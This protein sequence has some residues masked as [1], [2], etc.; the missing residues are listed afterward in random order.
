MTSPVYR[1]DQFGFLSVTGK[2]A[3]SFL[4][5]YTTCDLDALTESSVQLG[6]ICNLQGRMLTSFLVIRQENDLILRMDRALVSSTIEFLRKYIVFSKAALHDISDSYRCFGAAEVSSF[7]HKI[8]RED[9]AFTIHLGNRK[10]IW[11][12]A[13]IEQ[14]EEPGDHWLDLEIEQGMAWVTERNTEKFLPQ[15]FAYH[16]LNGIDFSKGCYLGQEIIARMQYRGELKRRLHRTRSPVRDIEGGDVIVSGSAAS[17]V[18]LNNTTDETIEV[19]QKS[20][21]VV[22]VPLRDA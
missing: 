15:T 12:S 4:Q 2:D 18:V 16:L 22:A 5:G 13:D 14:S 9:N 19:T 20:G 17:L 1:L 6:A 21:T 3:I 8:T 11:Q 7:D 10:E